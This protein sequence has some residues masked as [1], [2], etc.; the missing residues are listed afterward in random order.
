[1]GT[2]QQNLARFFKSVFA[3]GEDYGKRSCVS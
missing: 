3:R 1:M 2:D